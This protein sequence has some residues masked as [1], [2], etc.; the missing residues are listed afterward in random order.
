VC[1]GNGKGEENSKLKAGGLGQRNQESQMEDGVRERQGKS[2]AGI[3]R[4]GGNNICGGRRSPEA[5]GKNRRTKGKPIWWKKK[6]AFFTGTRGRE[7][8][9]QGRGFRKVFR[10]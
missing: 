1:C 3:R 7:K 2:V 6:R 9:S 5:E 10:R 8:K 4:G